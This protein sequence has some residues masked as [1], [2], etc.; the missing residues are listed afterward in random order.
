MW[1]LESVIDGLKRFCFGSLATYDSYERS[2]SRK[3]FV[4]IYLVCHIKLRNKSW[5]YSESGL[6]LRAN[7]RLHLLTFWIKNW[8]WKKLDFWNLKQQVSRHCSGQF[9]EAFTFKILSPENITLKVKLWDWP[10]DAGTICYSVSCSQ[11]QSS[12][13]TVPLSLKDSKRSQWTSFL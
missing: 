7:F 13:L 12:I 5:Q 2:L 1:F 11:I 4:A 3:N 9:C 6:T 8:V 10:S